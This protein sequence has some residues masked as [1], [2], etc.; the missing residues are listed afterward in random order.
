MKFAIV[1]CMFLSAAF[2][3]P[4]HPLLAFVGDGEIK[5]WRVVGGPANAGEFPYQGALLRV[6]GT[7]AS[8]TCGCW[9]INAR[10]IGTAAHCVAG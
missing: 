7:T 3:L 5:D 4:K 1:F 6:S 2:A 10:T 8:L 9:I